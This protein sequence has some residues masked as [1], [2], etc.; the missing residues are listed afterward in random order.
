VGKSSLLNALVGS[1]RAL[2]HEEPGTTRDV[3][4]AYVEWDG[5]AVRLFDTAGHREGVHPVEREGISRSRS[6][7]REA[8]VALWVVDGSRQ[9]EPEDLDL[10]QALYVAANK[11][12]LG[13]VDLGWV[14]VY[15]PSQ[16][17]V[18]SAKEG[19]GL[20]ELRAQLTSEGLKDLPEAETFEGVNE[21]HAHC[22]QE[23]V[24]GLERGARALESRRPAELAA[25]DLS[26]C[27]DAL[28]EILGEKAGPELLD[29]IFSRF[30]IGK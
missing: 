2:V 22:L 1:D 9:P 21:R 8:D 25:A 10:G 16:I 15:S 14:N 3:V 5:L 27:L 19:T 11:E 23:A 4:D 28:G 17:C 18:I 6:V 29:T 26:R 12:D 30:C 7:A 13:L 20:T 24:A